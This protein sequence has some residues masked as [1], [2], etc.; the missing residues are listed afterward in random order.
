MDKEKRIFNGSYSGSFLD[1]LAFPM[2]GIGAGMICLE[3]NGNLSQF[4][5]RH[6]PAIYNEPVVFSALYVKSNDVSET[7]V[8]EGQVPAWKLLHPWDSSGSGTGAAGKIFGLPRCRE[9]TFKA[10][11]PFGTVCLNEHK[12]PVS[13]ELTGWSPFIPG[14]ADNSSL[15]V[16]ALE[17]TFKNTSDEKIDVIYSFH[18]ANFMGK[19]Y[20]NREGLLNDV[21]TS[22]VLETENGFILWQPPSDSLPWDEGAFSVIIDDP[23]VRVN[24]H[25]FR[26]TWFD[27]ITMLWKSIVAGEMPDNPAIDETPPS[28]GGSL[29]IPF[30]LEAGE[31]KNIIVRIAWYVPE[32][33]ITINGYEQYQLPQAGKTH[34]PWYTTRFSDINDINEYWKSNYSELRVKSETFSECFFDTTLPL[35]VIEAI[36]ANLSILKSPTILRQTDGRIFGFEGCKDNEGCCPGSTNHVWTYAQSI[37]HLFPDLERSLRYTEVNENLDDRGHQYIWSSLPIKPTK[38]NFHIAADGQLGGCMQV[39][40]DWRISGDDKWLA[41]MWPKVKRS[42]NYCI[43]ELDPDNVGWVVEPHF[44]TYDVEFW[45]PDGMC[46]SYYIGALKSAQLMA[47]YLQDPDAVLYEDLYKKGREKME[48]SLW[49]G[50]YFQ[51]KIEWENLRANDP[52]DERRGFI[53]YYSPEALKILRKEGPKYQYGTGCLADGVIGAW[54][55]AV[56]GLDEIIDQEKVTSHLLSVYKN[57]FRE[58]LMSHANPQRSTYALG[59]EGGVLLCTWPKGDQPSLPFIYSSEVWTGI[60]YQVSAHLFMVGKIEEGLRI[61][62]AVRSRYDGRVRNPFDEFECGHYYARA[63]SSYSMIQGLSGARYDAVDE[64]LYIKPSIKGDFRSFISTATGYGT[65]GVRKGKPFLEVRNGVIPY[66][67]LIYEKAN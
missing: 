40:R 47:E 60:E 35:E 53:N 51:Q 4:S 26:G 38:H 58:S 28:P 34:K 19:Y 21:D 22:A 63:M 1:R 48:S 43:E 59:N 29:F 17:Y 36:A 11:F 10:R 14:D 56:C 37:P 46:T 9:A 7:R 45:G 39:Y 25:W 24:Y 49:N 55:A 33:D 23:Q 54:V 3:G 64:T 62:S 41:E 57:N 16:L 12:L 52:T 42:L 32:S 65:V 20:N 6:R 2:G 50:E 44:N 18:A 31:I 13:I 8:L 5:L 61:V 67:K 66:K 27:P 15:P 30:H